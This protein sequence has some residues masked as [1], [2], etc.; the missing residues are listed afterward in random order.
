MLL[1]GGR[2]LSTAVELEN[3]IHKRPP[4][5]AVRLWLPL[6]GIPLTVE[7]IERDPEA[8]EAQVVVSAVRHFLDAGHPTACPMETDGRWLVATARKEPLFVRLP[9]MT[10]VMDGLD[11]CGFVGHGDDSFGNC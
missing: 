3:P 10:Q 7:R 8:N 1:K 5:F 9:A 6:A 2:N 11:G 4:A